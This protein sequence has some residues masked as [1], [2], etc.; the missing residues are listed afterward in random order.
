MNS[1]LSLTGG[2]LLQ[3][4]TR[5]RIQPGTAGRRQPWSHYLVRPGVAELLT[6]AGADD[7]AGGFLGH[8][9]DDPGAAAPGVL[10][11]HGVNTR[12]ISA[13]QRDAHLDRQPPLRTRRTRLRWAA[14]PS[15]DG[16]QRAVFTLSGEGHRTLSVQAPVDD[17]AAVEAFCADLAL[18]DWL[19]TS[20]VD[21]ADRAFT[22]RRPPAE[23]LERLRPAIDHLVHVWMPGVRVTDALAGLWDELERRSRLSLQWQTTVTRIRDHVS[24]GMVDGLR[25]TGAG[26]GGSR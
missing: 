21:V 13:V 1:H 9:G 15:Q 4:A 8:P 20:L 18:H 12:L 24:L 6:G 17:V 25:D 22:G 23:V 3:A 2:H 14:R 26:N 19:L 10:D 7:V 16:T 11:L 5:V